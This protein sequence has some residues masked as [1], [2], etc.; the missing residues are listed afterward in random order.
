MDESWEHLQHLS[1]ILT[2]D[3][4]DFVKDDIPIPQQQPATG[5][6]PGRI[7]LR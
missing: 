6:C 1:E 3:V 5:I 7:R 2:E 4:H